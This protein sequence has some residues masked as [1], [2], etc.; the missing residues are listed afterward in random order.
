MTT[1]ITRTDLPDNPEAAYAKVSELLTEHRQAEQR[2]I[3]LRGQVR[4]EIAGSGRGAVARLAATTGVS[5]VAA[6]RVLVDDLVRAVRTVAEDT[7]FERDEYRVREAGQAYPPR[8]YLSIVDDEEDD[9]TAGWIGMMNGAGALLDGLVGEM[10]VD[11]GGDDP[12]RTLARGDEV[13]VT[14]YTPAPVG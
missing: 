3:A 11:A 5:H 10:E 9:G 4:R 13:T 8:V 12:R 1:L 2:L 14:W 6:G 7:G